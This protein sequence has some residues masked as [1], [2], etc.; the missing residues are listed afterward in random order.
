[1]TDHADKTQTTPANPTSPAKLKD[2]PKPAP[3]ADLEAEIATEVE[4][5][6]LTDDEL[7]SGNDI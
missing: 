1:M 7:N 3:N 2:K 4:H 5:G 6:Q